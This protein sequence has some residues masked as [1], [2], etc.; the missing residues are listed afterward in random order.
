M[1]SPVGGRAGGRAG[2]HER[3]AG[4]AHVDAGAIRTARHDAGIGIA[5]VRLVLQGVPSYGLSLILFYGKL[6]LEVKVPLV[7]RGMS[8]F[9]KT[10]NTSRASVRT[11]ASQDGRP[12]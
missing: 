3:A 12:D 7:S 2:L 11:H 8:K 1:P 4:N 9:L 5:G 10:V 6:S